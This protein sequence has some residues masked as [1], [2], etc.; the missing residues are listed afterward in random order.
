MDT[1]VVNGN[2]SE[3]KKMPTSKFLMWVAI[4]SIIMMFGGFTSAYVVKRNQAS[5]QSFDLPSIFWV[6][7]A[8]I[9]LSSITL[10]ICVQKFKQGKS[11]LPFFLITA[12]LGVLFITFQLKGFDE[13]TNSG[14]KM[15]GTGSV[16]SGSFLYVIAGIHI[17][18]ILGGLVAIFILLFKYGTPEKS[19]RAGALPL[20][21]FSIYWH[22]IGILWI[23]L[24][25]FFYFAR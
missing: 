14:V 25:V 7:T 6:S 12:I 24:V 18:H 13:V 4:A 23:Y 16:V 11:I 17:L 19:K 20:E 3:S 8:L 5:W 2:V 22:F 9:I 15:I 10:Y 21:V 1:V